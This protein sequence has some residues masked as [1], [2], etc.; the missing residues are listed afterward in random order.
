MRKLALAFVATTFAIPAH[1]IIIDTANLLQIQAPNLNVVADALVLAGLPAQIVFA[2][3]QNVLLNA[4][5]ATDTGIIPAGS[6][7]SSYF[8]G[9]NALSTNENFAALTS[10]TFSQP[11]LG[12]VY[13]ESLSG[14]ASPNY[15]LTNFLGAPSVTYNEQTCLFCGFETFGQQTGLLLDRIAISDSAR[16]ISFFNLYSSPGDYARIITGDTV[17]VPGPIV[18]AGIPGLIAALGGLLG[19]RW[20]RR[21]QAA[22]TV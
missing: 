4:P 21:R 2:E 9:L 17:P 13:Q 22:M 12:V 7:V 11:I 8:F 18:G 3:Q 19:L 20:R 5:L 6:T 1:A 15:Q 16:T 14:V 10:I